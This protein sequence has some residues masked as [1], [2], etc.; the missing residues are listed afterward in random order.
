MATVKILGVRLI[1]EFAPNHIS[2]PVS[3]ERGIG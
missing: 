2:E 1:A 3:I